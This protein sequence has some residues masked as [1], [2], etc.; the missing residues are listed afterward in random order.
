MYKLFLHKS[1]ER[2]SKNDNISLD[3]QQQ[4]CYNDNQIIDNL[5]IKGVS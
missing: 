5:I 4:M 1:C 2:I 3:K